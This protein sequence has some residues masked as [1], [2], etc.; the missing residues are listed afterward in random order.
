MCDFCEYYK[1][2]IREA[3]VFYML[4]IFDTINFNYLHCCFANPPLIL[5]KNRTNKIYSKRH[6]TPYGTAL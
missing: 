3:H 5:I 4:Y 6:I 2:V 1:A